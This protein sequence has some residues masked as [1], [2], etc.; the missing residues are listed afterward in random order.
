MPKQAET[1]AGVLDVDVLI[2]GGGIAGASLATALAR[3]RKRV[4]ILEATDRYADRIW[5]ESLM[6]WGVVEAEALG[7]ADVLREAGAHTATSWH[8]WSEG[9]AEPREVRVGRLVPGVGGTL[10]LAHPVACQALLDAAVDAGARV[11]RGVDSVEIDPERPFASFRRQGSEFV[12]RA[13]VI[14]GA[15]GRASTV[16]RQIGLELDEHGPT[17]VVAGLLLEGVSG[18]VD[19]DV[20]AEHDRGMSLLLHQGN[21][22]ARAYHVVPM[23]DRARYAGPFGPGRFIDDLAAAGGPL[24]E[25]ASAMPAGPCGAVP[26]LETSTDLP[27]AGR[28]VLIGDAAGQS[29]PS[30]G[31]GPSVAMRDARMVRDLVLDGATCAEEFAEYGAARAELLRRLRLIARVMISSVVEPGAD[32]ADRRA[33]FRDAMAERDPEVFP[34]V[35]GLFTGPDTIPDDLVA[36]GVPAVF[37]AA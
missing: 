13:D 20:V 27:A 21:G 29:D 15:D 10:N 36:A 28:V 30:I 1:D 17:A 18:P 23:G 11:W 12:V 14:V 2:V 24:A 22:R 33:R 6:P 16:R 31:C 3:E 34:L 9:D 8:R 19:R 32:R 25:L 35:L 5:G 26:N 4:G 37:S 7:V